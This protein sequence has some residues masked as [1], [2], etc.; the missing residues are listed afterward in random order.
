MQGNVIDVLFT[1]I[2]CTLSGM[3]IGGGGL[4]TVYFSVFRNIP[5]LYCQG[6]NLIIFTV[7]SFCSV[8]VNIQKRNINYRYC[9]FLSL[10]GCIGACLGCCIAGIISEKYLKIGFGFFLLVTSISVF[11]KNKKN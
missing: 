6:I 11:V 1:F 2:F 10:C 3:G 4:L 8:L 9:I 5:Q 7:C